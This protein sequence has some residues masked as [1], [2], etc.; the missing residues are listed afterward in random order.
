MSVKK[1]TAE[2]NIKTK[3]IT[4]NFGGNFFFWKNVWSR[5]FVGIFELRGLQILPDSRNVFE[6]SP[7]W[8]ELS[9][10]VGSFELGSLLVRRSQDQSWH[11]Q[12]QKV[13]Q[14]DCSGK[15]QLTNGMMVE[16]CSSVLGVLCSNPRASYCLSIPL[17]L[18]V[19]LRHMPQHK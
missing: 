9:A 7:A 10:R 17:W 1:S 18:R 16:W 11:F 5:I 3:Q 8:T 2:Q 15:Y 12:S 6:R 14:G 19:L 4:R 13:S